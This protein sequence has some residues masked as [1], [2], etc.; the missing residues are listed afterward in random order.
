M[1]FVVLLG[2]LRIETICSVDYRCGLMRKK[3]LSSIFPGGS[4]V[5]EST[6]SAGALQEIWVR[7][8]GWGDTLEKE[9]ATQ[10]SILAWKIPLT[11]SDTMSD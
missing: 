11:E 9:M 2:E 8:L 6:C 7:S 1:P 10:S 3:W 5:R 4:V